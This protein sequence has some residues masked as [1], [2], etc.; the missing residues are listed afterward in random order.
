MRTPLMPMASAMAAKFGLTSSVPVSRKPVDFCSSSM[1]QKCVTGFHGLVARR[2]T[3]KAGHSDVVGIIPLDMLFA[4]Q[5]VDDRAFRGFGGLHQ[6]VV[7]ALAAAAAEQRDAP[8][9]VEEI[10]QLV[11][12]LIG[13]HD[14]R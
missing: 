7:R 10:S 3:Y 2:E 6:L 1:H 13:G 14:N 8:G 9:R 11:E 12:R 4:S 5:G